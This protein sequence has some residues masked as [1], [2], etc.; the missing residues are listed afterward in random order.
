MQAVLLAHQGLGED[1]IGT[2]LSSAFDSHEPPRLKTPQ[3]VRDWLDG[4]GARLV[5]AR[6][7]ES[8]P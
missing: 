4:V 5:A 8:S 6:T 1:R 2:A 7:L 3:E